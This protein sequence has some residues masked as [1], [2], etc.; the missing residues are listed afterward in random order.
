MYQIV[1]HPCDN[2]WNW[3]G[4]WTNDIWKWKGR[5]NLK[6]ALF[7]TLNMQTWEN[8]PNKQHENYLCK[9]NHSDLLTFEQISKCWILGWTRE[10]RWDKIN[11]S[12]LIQLQVC[13]CR[14]Y[15][16]ESTTVFVAQCNSLV[17]YDMIQFHSV[18]Y[19]SLSFVLN[20]K[21]L[22]VEV[23]LKN[24]MSQIGLFSCCITFKL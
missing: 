18:L 24:N 7:W 17:S 8:F 23:I 6:T 20:N 4:E 19:L 9:I 3:Q 14:E 16:S 15:N 13:I 11:P 10:T 22:C 5:T 1:S 12:R 21:I 2:I